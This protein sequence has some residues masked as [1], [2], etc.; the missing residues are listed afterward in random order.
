MSDHMRK[1]KV[2]VVL[3]GTG[4]PTSTWGDDVGVLVGI[5]HGQ[6]HALRIATEWVADNLS[7]TKKDRA[8]WTEVEGNRYVV[9]KR[10]TVG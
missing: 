10:W 3:T 4:R 5:Y 7:K 9:V 8:T 1:Q 2:W 6:K